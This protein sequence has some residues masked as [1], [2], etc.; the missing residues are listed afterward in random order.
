M[1]MRV[2]GNRTLETAMRALFL[3][4]LVL[5]IIALSATAEETQ[6]VNTFTL[7]EK[8]PAAQPVGGGPTAR[9][10]SD[11]SQGVPV[12]EAQQQQEEA[13][14]RVRK[15]VEAGV[16]MGGV[17]GK[18]AG[19]RLDYGKDDKALARGYAPNPCPD[20]GFAMSLAVSGS[21][22]EVKRRGERR[23]MDEDGRPDL[24]ER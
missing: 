21:D 17:S 18:Y 16:A 19:A 8:K 1:F 5:S 3:T 12:S 20:T 15:T 10:V 9:T 7:L 23:P 2:K 4:G 24:M 6:P 11:Y 13:K 22:M 14:C